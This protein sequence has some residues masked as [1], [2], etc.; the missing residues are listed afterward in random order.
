ML[1]RRLRG[2]GVRVEPKQVQARGLI[3]TISAV[4]RLATTYAR[5]RK[6]K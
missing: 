6:I 2:R 3:G 1:G 5:I 4:E